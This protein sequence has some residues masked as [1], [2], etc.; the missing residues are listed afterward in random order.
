M[1]MDTVVE[2]FKHLSVSTANSSRQQS[3]ARKFVKK[4]DVIPKLEI[5]YGEPRRKALEL[6]EQTWIGKFMGA[7]PNQKSARLLDSKLTEFPSKGLFILLPL[8]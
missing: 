1:A 5:L 8:W 4:M 7:W 6:V 2:A 3:K